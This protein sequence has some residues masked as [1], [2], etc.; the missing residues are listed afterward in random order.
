M[1]GHA[2]CENSRCL[3]ISGA[4]VDRAIEDVGVVDE[5]S[6]LAVDLEDWRGQDDRVE[7]QAPALAKQVVAVRVDT[8]AECFRCERLCEYRKFG[9]TDFAEWNGSHFAS[10]LLSKHSEDRVVWR[11]H[12][13]QGEFLR[14]D[15]TESVWSIESYF[16]GIEWWRIPET[17]K[18]EDLA[19]MRSPGSSDRVAFAIR[20]VGDD[21]DE[22][23]ECR[24]DR[25]ESLTCSGAWVEEKLV[26]EELVALG[27]VEV[28]LGAAAVDLLRRHAEVVD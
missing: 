18:G 11:R 6:R 9:G 15:E 22:I 23:R 24:H 13:V 1:F 26:A 7:R 28:P 8:G 21:Q 3:K 16:A 10:A 5:G 14:D 19:A 17:P 2:L 12:E 25:S 27:A 20:F 4:L